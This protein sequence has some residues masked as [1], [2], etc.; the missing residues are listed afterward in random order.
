VSQPVEGVDARTDRVAQGTVGVALLAAFVFRIPWLVPG[1]SLLL[2]FGALAGPRANGLH[3]ALERWVTPRLP[4]PSATAEEETVAVPT[5]RAQDALAAAILAAASFAFLLGIGLVG[6]VL[7]LAEA[8]IAIIAA[9]TR[10]HLG[11]RLRR[12]L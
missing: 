11:D 1:L 4:A 6:W 3:R 2:A 9:T 10:I 7:A 8:V 5:V 12:A